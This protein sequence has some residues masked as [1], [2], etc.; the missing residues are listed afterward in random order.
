MNKADLGCAVW[1]SGCENSVS[2]GGDCDLTLQPPGDIARLAAIA[3]PSGFL[4]L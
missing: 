4:S 3:D 2:E 1:T